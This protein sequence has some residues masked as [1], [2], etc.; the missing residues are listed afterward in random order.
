MPHV[1]AQ[2]NDPRIT[3]ERTAW[4]AT[5]TV[6]RSVQPGVASAGGTSAAPVPG[7]VTPTPVGY[8]P[9]SSP[10]PSRNTVARDALPPTAIDWPIADSQTPEPAPACPAGQ[11]R[12]TTQSLEV[13]ATTGSR[14]EAK[15]VA[16]AAVEGESAASAQSSGQMPMT[17]VVPLAPTR[18][19]GRRCT[20]RH[21]TG[22]VTVA[23]QRRSAI[24]TRGGI[25]P[26]A[27]PTGTRSL[28]RP[29][30]GCQWQVSS[31][32]TTARCRWMDVF[33]QKPQQTS[34]PHRRL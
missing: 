3:M 12:P 6:L 17:F 28:S 18:C 21:R 13:H 30:Q 20:R 4:P 34:L 26:R 23:G 27:R 7:P 33:S 29:V 5:D 22:S 2:P 1:A 10:H 15:K 31:V 19:H 32:P 11:G 9:P 25:R 14:K 8:A 24:A 16:R